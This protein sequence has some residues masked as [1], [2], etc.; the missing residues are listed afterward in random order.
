[1]LGEGLTAF[2]GDRLGLKRALFT[3]LVLT[4]LSFILLPFLGS[5]LP[6][7]LAGLFFTFLTFEFAVV[8]GI[9]LFT[10]ILPGARAT[11]MSSNVAAMSIGR[12][13]GALVGGAIW[14]AGGLLAICLVSAAICGLA[15]AC[16]AW[17]LR[18]WRT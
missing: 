18:H 17:G 12:M 14:L 2:L 10:E 13:I 1:L 7:A 9:S 16:L 11:M 6:L 8:T 4:A 3:G 15:L 5:T